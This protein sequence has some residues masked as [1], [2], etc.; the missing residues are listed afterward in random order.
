MANHY[1][2]FKGKLKFGVPYLD[3]YNGN[4]HYAIV[5]E[6][7][8]PAASAPALSA[9]QR[10]GLP[11]TT[12]LHKEAER[13]ADERCEVLPFDR[14]A[15]PEVGSGEKRHA[16]NER[17]AGAEPVHVVE[18]VERVGEADEPDDGDGCGATTR[19]RRPTG[20]AASAP[21]ASPG[22]STPT[23]AAGPRAG[24]APK[25]SR[26]SRPGRNGCDRCRHKSL[27]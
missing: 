17:D 8:E 1:C 20:P 25:R 11:A 9:E 27:G 12:V 23:T 19:A 16:D 3:G 14:C 6:A 5:V 21:G 13:G 22:P 18:Q 24:R 7:H 10:F 15:S 26:K 4:P 2:M